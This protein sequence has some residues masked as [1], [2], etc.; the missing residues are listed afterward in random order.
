M[1]IEAELREESDRAERREMAV[2]G[3]LPYAFLAVSTVITLAQPQQVNLPAVLGLTLVSAIWV[4]WFVTLHPQWHTPVPL[5]GVYYAGLVV[6]AAGLVTL[7]PWYGIFAFVCYVHA[8]QFLK[9]RWRYAGVVATSMIMAVTYMGGIDRI[10]ADEWWLWSAIT[11]VGIVLAGTFFYFAEK[12]DQRTDRQKRAFTEL[13]EAN[14]RLEAA[15]EENA[16]LHS[17]LLAQAREAGVMDERH[18]MAREIHDTLAQGLGGILTQLQAAEQHR[19]QPSTA[20]RHVK[21]ARELAR[22][23]LAEARRTVHAV[24]PEALSAARLPEAIGDLSRRW[25]EANGVGADLTVTGDPR[26]MHAEVE[27]ALLRVAQ[28]ALA[29]IAK[30]AGARRVGLTLSYMEDVVTLDVR[31]DGAGFDPDAVR[32]SDPDVGGFGLTGMRQRVRRVAGRVDIES[33]PGAGTAVSASVPAI[34]AR[35]DGR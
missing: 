33:E 16:G 10:G 18:R 1:S 25:S 8:F 4:L 13:H 5:M 31:D 28:E 30:H 22:E 21:N 19:D 34:P 24:G 14:L 23:S 27:I 9:G 26:S 20:A 7:A 12:T 6:L 3:A 15:L 35:E 17:Q 29:N 32:S 11:L 2:V